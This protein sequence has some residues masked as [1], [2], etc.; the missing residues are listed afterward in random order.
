MG[1]SV[2]G[3]VQITA[4][5][6]PQSCSRLQIIADLLLKKKQREQTNKKRPRPKRR[7][8]G[9]AIDLLIQ[10]Q[11]PHSSLVSEHLQRNFWDLE[12]EYLWEPTYRKYRKLPT[13]PPRYDREKR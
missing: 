6:T 1:R 9:K 8:I 4:W 10:E 5:I 13:K 2:T 12:K 11:W 7:E 3:R